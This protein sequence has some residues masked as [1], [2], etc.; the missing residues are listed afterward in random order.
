M[1]TPKGIEKKKIIK[2]IKYVC[3]IQWPPL[4]ISY[5]SISK[6][7]FLNYTYGMCPNIDINVVTE[8]MLHLLILALLMY[9]SYSKVVTLP[10][11]WLFLLCDPSPSR[12][13]TH[14]WSASN[15]DWSES[16]QPE[17]LWFEWILGSPGRP[18]V[19]IFHRA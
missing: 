17:L 2:L 7:Y 6:L 9:L 8:L 19:L 3:I 15:P 10:S 14:L 11:Y 5:F 4:F 16:I 13:C 1:A 18:A 12:S